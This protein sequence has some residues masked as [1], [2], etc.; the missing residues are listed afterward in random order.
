[1]RGP[2]GAFFRGFNRVFD[3]TTTGYVGVS[4]L[5]VRRSFL[6]IAIVA[7]V[8]VGAGL[9][10]PPPLEGVHGIEVVPA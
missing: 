8:A 5:L 10:V 2:L 3:A 1:M 9:F 6:T 4:R 7:V